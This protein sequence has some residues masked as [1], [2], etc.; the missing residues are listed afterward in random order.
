MT[1][2]EPGVTGRPGHGDHFTDHM[3]SM[4]WHPRHG[5]REA[6]LG[7][8]RELTL[9]PATIGIHYGQAIFEGLKAFRQTD[10]S[11]A[12]FRPR[13]NA[14][15]FQ[16]SASRLAMPPLPEQLFLDAVESLAA[17]DASCVPMDPSYSLYLR[18]LMFGTDRNLMLRPSDC[19]RFLVI[20]FVAGG[21]FGEGVD[22]ISVRVNHE[23]AR[24]MPGGTGDVKVAG[25]YAPTFAAQLAADRE[26]CQQ[27]VWLDSAQGRWIEEMSGMNL[28]LVAGGGY[29]PEIVTPALTGTLL[30]GITRDT[31]LTLARRLGF[32]VREQRISLSQWRTASAPGGR[33]TEAFACGTAAVVTAVGSVRDIGGDWS[34]GNGRPGPVTAALRTALMDAQC[35]RAPDVDGWLHPVPGT[36]RSETVSVGRGVPVKIRG[37]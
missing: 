13:D 14:L 30:P 29:R 3:V 25:N 5:W 15:R 20:A 17:A 36:G 31:I 22:A 21:F 23:H 37:R 35:G 8:L 18:P 1:D 27:V 19:Y 10:G 6:E 24:A 12:V 16:R 26:G 33:F 2:T 4:D 28:F 32:T 11:I 7:P 34:I 9:H